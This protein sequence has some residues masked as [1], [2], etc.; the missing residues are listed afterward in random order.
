MLE[1]WNNSTF[2][3]TAR[4]PEPFHGTTTVGIKVRDGVVLAADKRA[5]AGHLIA[6]RTVKKIVRITNNVA[7]TIAGVVADAQSL[8][9]TVKAEMEYYSISSKVKPRVRNY[10]NLL[11]RILFSS[12]WFPYIV[13]LIV[14]GYDDSP[15]LYTLDWYGSILEE[16]TFTSTGSGSPIAF[17]VLEEGY[18]ENMT[19]EEAVELARKAVRAATRRDSASGDG[20][21]VLI[22][23]RN[24]SRE[25][26]IKF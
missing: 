8:A 24:G 16:D 1:A 22:I 13:Q 5:T 23:T 7:M 20:V 15:R 4:T 14:G 2:R 11:A 19:I 6:S 3:D 10:A 18:N 26:T 21:D 25:L 17:G 12:K 9:D